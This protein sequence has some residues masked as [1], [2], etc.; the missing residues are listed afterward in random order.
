METGN[1]IL[2]INTGLLVDYVHTATF[3]PDS[4]LI[5]TGGVSIEDE[6]IQIWDANTGI[7]VAILKGHERIVNCLAWTADGRTLISGSFAKHN[8]DLEH[9]HLAAARSFDRP[10]QCCQRHCNISEWPHPRK[11]ILG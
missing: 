11:R 5:A 3:S 1:T 2:E 10:L 6:F 4:T 9:F 7:L 8:H